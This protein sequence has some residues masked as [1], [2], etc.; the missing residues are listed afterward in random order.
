VPTGTF[1]WT[2]LLLIRQFMQPEPDQPLWYV[3]LQQCALGNTTD[4]DTRTKND[5]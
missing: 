3:Y 2:G 5:H 4:K 1:R